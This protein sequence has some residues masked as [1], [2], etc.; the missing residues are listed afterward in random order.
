MEYNISIYKNVLLGRTSLWLLYPLYINFLNNWNNLNNWNWNNITNTLIYIFTWLWIFTTSIISYT[1][2]EI[3]DKKSLLLYNL[4]I[5]FARGTFAL[6]SYLTFIVRKPNIKL[7]TLPVGVGT[8]Y[9]LTNKFYEYEYYVYSIFSH[10]I[11]RYIGF[12]WTYIVFN[13]SIPNNIFVVLSY[14]YLI[15]IFYLIN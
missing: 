9:L 1:M 3:Y 12:W 11:F 7:V 13:N 4:D 2:W 5:I 15:H 6:L 14:T 8:F 10:L